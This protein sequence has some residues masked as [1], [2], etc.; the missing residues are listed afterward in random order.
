M[1]QV[2]S[3]HNYL[4]LLI[5]AAGILHIPDVL[6][7]GTYENVSVLRQAA[8]ATWVLLSAET[9]LSRLESSSLQKVFAVNTFGPILI[10][11]ASRHSIL[12]QSN[13]L[14]FT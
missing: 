10:S 11:K 14:S 5:N 4:T 7:P 9:A 6:S 13:L 1:A 3:K 8:V 2:S 12:P